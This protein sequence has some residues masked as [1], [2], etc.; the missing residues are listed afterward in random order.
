MLRAYLLPALAMV[1]AVSSLLTE[2]V[3]E[4]STIVGVYLS[5]VFILE[6]RAQANNPSGCCV[7]PAS[8]EKTTPNVTV[9]ART[10]HSLYENCACR[11]TYVPHHCLHAPSSLCSQY[12][13]ALSPTSSSAP[14]SVC[15]LPWDLTSYPRPSRECPS[16]RALYDPQSF[17]PLPSGARPMRR[18]L[19]TSSAP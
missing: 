10:R 6:A 18:R 3:L 2:G 7:R 4:A 14:S 8:P 11:M 19:T 16:T 9:P 5:I 13:C 12:L 17:D 15:S 1:A